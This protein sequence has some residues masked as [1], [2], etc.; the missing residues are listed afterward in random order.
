MGV[1][2][3]NLGRTHH[4]LSGVVNHYATNS[5]TTSI[6]RIQQNIFG[7]LLYIGTNITPDMKAGKISFWTTVTVSGKYMEDTYQGAGGVIAVKL[8]ENYS[9]PSA[10]DRNN[11]A[12]KLAVAIAVYR[13][14]GYRA[15][16]IIQT[17]K[18]E[19]KSESLT[20]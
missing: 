1:D 6:K 18:S 16:E 15:K 17:F 12:N 8:E 11:L 19:M 2:A 13:N 14:N 3:D 5:L 20:F 7:M 10:P 4:W 9:A